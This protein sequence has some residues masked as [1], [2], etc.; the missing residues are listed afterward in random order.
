[1]KGIFVLLLFWLRL[2]AQTQELEQLKLDLEKLVQFKLI[3]SQMKQGYQTLQNGYNSVRDAAK[4]N[5]DLHKNYLDGLLRVSPSV[6]QSPGLQAVGI[7]REK[8]RTLFVTAFTKFKTSGLFGAAELNAMQDQYNLCVQKTSDDLEVLSQVTSNG[9]LRMSDAERLQVIDLVRN[10]VAA[11]HG[12][13]QSLVAEQARLLA[14]RLQQKKDMEALK[15]LS[16]LK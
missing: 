7:D 9:Q 11:Q 5:Y 10:D 4:G 6:K 15:K 2:N 12:I 13:V 1:M 8:M 14:L 16:G 3:L